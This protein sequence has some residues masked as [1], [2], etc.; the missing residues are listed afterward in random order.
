VPAPSLKLLDTIAKQCNASPEV[1]QS[2]TTSITS[3]QL[4]ALTSTV[5]SLTAEQI[6]P[7]CAADLIAVAQALEAR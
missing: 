5:E 7:A 4:E 6:P 1:E 3:N 2:L